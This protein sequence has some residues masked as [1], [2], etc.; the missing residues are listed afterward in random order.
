MILYIYVT[1]TNLIIA[2]TG[3]TLLLWVLRYL[4]LLMEYKEFKRIYYNG[5]PKAWRPNLKKPSLFFK[6]KKNKK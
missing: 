5:S 6:L 4:L 2:L 3:S 1:Q